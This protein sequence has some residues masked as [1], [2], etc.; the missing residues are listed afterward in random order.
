MKP[1]GPEVFRRYVVDG[2]VTS[3]VDDVD[4]VIT[5]AET[6]PDLHVRS[7]KQIDVPVIL[8]GPQGCMGNI[9]F[10]VLLQ[11]Q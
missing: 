10:P 4:G 1:L 3:V 7:I 5:G 6:L 8:H 2:G 9:A 11:A